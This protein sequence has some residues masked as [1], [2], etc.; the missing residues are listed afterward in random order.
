MVE[1]KK[2]GRKKARDRF[3]EG[4]V[5]R[6]EREGKEDTIS[7]S[8]SYCRSL[9]G[10]FSHVFCTLCEGNVTRGPKVANHCHCA[11]LVS[12]DCDNICLASRAT[13]VNYKQ[14]IFGLV[15]VIADSVA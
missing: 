12:C 10:G 14:V 11:Y 5:R 9:N 6:M 3:E 13:P 4:Q 8:F 1:G 7:E 2:K 15:Q